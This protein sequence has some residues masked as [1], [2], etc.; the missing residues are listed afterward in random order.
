MLHPQRVKA[1]ASARLK[2]DRVDSETLAHLSRRSAA[3]GLDGER[4]DAAVDAAADYARPGK[5]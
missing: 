1:I 3:E 2:N 5:E 4:A